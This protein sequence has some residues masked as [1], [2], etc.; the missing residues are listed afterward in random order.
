M[1]AWSPP[2]TTESAQTGHG[3][4]KCPQEFWGRQ[5]DIGKGWVEA[6]LKVS[7]HCRADFETTTFLLRELSDHSLCKGTE[8]PNLKAADNGPD[9][10][11]AF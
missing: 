9:V 5:S 7:M 8:E 2:Q 3:L 6:F 10:V 11:P 1:L 4:S